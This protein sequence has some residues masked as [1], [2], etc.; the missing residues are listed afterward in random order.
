MEY[1]LNK[2]DS[3]AYV[4]ILAVL[5]GILHFLYWKIELFCSHDRH[6]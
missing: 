6:D 4:K 3:P 1:H 5:A 2:I